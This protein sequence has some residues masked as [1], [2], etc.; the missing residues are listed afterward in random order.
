MDCTGGDGVIDIGGDY[1]AWNTRIALFYLTQPVAGAEI[2][3]TV[4]PQSLAAAAWECDGIEMTPEAAEASFVGVVRR[5]YV[6]NVLNNSGG[7]AALAQ[8]EVG[9]NEPSCLGFLA[10]AVLAAYRMRADSKNRATAYYPRLAELLACEI[11][12]GMPAG[13]VPEAFEQLW[14]L[15]RKW[16]LR[17]N[18]SPLFVPTQ[19]VLRKYE[20]FPLAH[21]VLRQMDVE[22]L[23]SFFEWAQY[24]PASAVSTDR[25]RH[26]FLRWVSE[27]RKLTRQGLA[28]CLD[29]R[30]DAVV[31]E[32]A[33][34]LKAWNGS[35]RDEEGRRIASVELTL[36]RVR[37]TP[38]VAYLA[39]RPPGF[40]AVFDDGTHRLDALEDGWFDPIPVPQDEGEAL[41]G[42]F[43]WQSRAGG[44]QF[45]LRRAGGPV[46]SL[47]RSEDYTGWISRRRLLA[48]VDC[49][50]LYHSSVAREVENHVR[51]ISVNTPR[52]EVESPPLPHGWRLLSDVRVTAA[53]VAVPPKLEALEVDSAVEIMATRG[54]R[55]GRRA[56]WL[57]GAEPTLLI[58]GAEVDV[59]VDGRSVKVRDGK[60]L[61]EHLCQQ[62]GVHIVQAGSTH[63][64][65]EIVAPVVS[66][67]ALAH[68]CVSLPVQHALSLHRGRWVLLGVAPGE[69][70]EIDMLQRAGVARCPFSPAW[71]IRGGKKEGCILFVGDRS[72][73]PLRSGFLHDASAAR[74]WAETILQAAER[75]LPLATIDQRALLDLN[76]LWLAYVKRARSLTVVPAT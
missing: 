34:E 58:S 7:M 10:L 64:R 12:R 36:D 52:P 67:S 29:S 16:T 24:A 51:N 13:F 69:R 6:L 5:F 8:A 65:Y 50:I 45:I 37:G 60:I 28:T 27:S 76:R 43:A 54:L 55:V 15:A 38:E 56:T 68:G 3:L 19:R 49:A 42:G 59:R 4:T 22:R 75:K 70:S 33:Q 31:Q 40:P 1:A 30:V 72:D 46:V 63:R 39:R 2:Y 21:A 74:R 11:R 35:V 41:L 20:Q 57:L 71:A 26:D 25:L 62:H 32:V 53:G 17:A 44:Q 66:V 14:T 47:V 9:R 18:M 61:W 48:G 73:A 23:P